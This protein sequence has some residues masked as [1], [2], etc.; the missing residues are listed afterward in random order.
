MREGKVNEA[1]GGKS[2]TCCE[3]GDVPMI[4]SIFF[5][6]SLAFPA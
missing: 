5:L 2:N 1:G 6:L 4:L 3:R